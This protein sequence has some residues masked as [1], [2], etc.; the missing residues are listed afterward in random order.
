MAMENVQFAQGVAPV[1]PA[2]PIVSTQP[3]PIVPGPE[4]AESSNKNLI[5]LIIAGLIIVLLLAGV[6]LYIFM[7]SSKSTEISSLPMPTIEPSSSQTGEVKS[8]VAVVNNYSDLET[9]MTELNQADGALEK[10][11]ASLEKDSNF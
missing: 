7:S 1:T 4:K 9:L 6:G 3:G 10:D 8:S 11:L 5:L 2:V